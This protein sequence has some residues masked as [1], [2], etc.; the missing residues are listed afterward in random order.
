M[1]ERRF[2]LW[3]V[4]GI[5][6]V[7]LAL[8]TISA[9]GGLALGYQW[10]RAS[11]IALAERERALLP[12]EAPRSVWPGFGEPFENLANQ[13]YLGVQFEMITPELAE[14]ENLPVEEGALIRQVVPNGPAEKAGLKTGD[15]VQQVDG[16]SVSAKHPL[17]ERIVAH[18]PGDE[19]TLKILR[20]AETLEI[21]VTLESRPAS[22]PF[23]LPEG[24]FPPDFN[25]RIQC[26]PE[27][28]PPLPFLDNDR[29]E[30]QPT[31]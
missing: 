20:N 24:R 31:D 11:G 3:Q 27:P 8:C 12:Q 25:F 29:P 21:K 2:S 13:P 23:S 15:I 7:V 10:G 17:R 22:L 1:V 19:V 18:Q 28:C 6:A 26:S 5:L 16:E 9:A 30:D 4:L 14:S